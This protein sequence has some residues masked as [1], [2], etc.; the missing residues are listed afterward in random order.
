[1]S[2]ANRETFRCL[3]DLQDIGVGSS[4]IFSQ[5][6]WFIW[7][8]QLEHFDKI[9]EFPLSCRVFTYSKIQMERLQEKQ[10]T[11]SI[12]AH[13]LISIFVDYSNCSRFKI[14]CSLSLSVSF[15]WLGLKIRKKKHLF[16]STHF[17]YKYTRVRK[18]HSNWPSHGLCRQHNKTNN[19]I[20]NRWTG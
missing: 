17:I 19:W 1:M 7:W 12:G 14:F 5:T 8:F 20:W 3:L 10:S 18:I 9:N 11:E 15:G 13:H 4:F 16:L 2:T 6:D